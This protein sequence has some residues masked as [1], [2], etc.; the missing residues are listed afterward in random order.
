MK[1]HIWAFVL[2]GLF[3]GVFIKANALFSLEE[4]PQIKPKITLHPPE[5]KVR[6]GETVTFSILCSWQGEE[7]RFKFL[8]PDDFKA[9]NL[10]YLHAGQSIESGADKVSKQFNFEF[11]P[12]KEGPAQIDGFDLSYKSKE[13]PNAAFSHPIPA[14]TLQITSSAAKQ[15]NL[16]RWISFA[17]GILAGMGF[18]FIAKQR[19]KPIKLTEL[20]SLEAEKLN[21]LTRLLEATQKPD[22]DVKKQ[23]GETARILETYKS[24][25]WKENETAKLSKHDLNQISEIREM[26][27][28]IERYQFGGFTFTQKEFQ[29]LILRI[30]SLIGRNQ[31]N[32]PSHST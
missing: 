22:A 19:R 4:T 6:V 26:M 21:K 3:V 20:P 27:R 30:K 24:Q 29:D 1:K 10:H 7:N 12:I 23:L 16:F 28:E 25:K 31:I 9:S 8:I 18:F 15:S 5:Q 14:I 11:E 32:E 13:E 17:L 2:I